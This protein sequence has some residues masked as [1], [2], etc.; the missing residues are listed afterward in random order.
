MTPTPQTPAIDETAVCKNCNELIVFRPYVTQR[1][2]NPLTN[3]PIWWHVNSMLVTCQSSSTQHPL[4]H[5]MIAS[6]RMED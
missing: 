5:L 4:A 2:I 3:G 1:K 6:P